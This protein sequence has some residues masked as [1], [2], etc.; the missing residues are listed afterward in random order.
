M[1][2]KEKILLCY[3]LGEDTTLYST[4][5]LLVQSN[6]K[7]IKENGGILR[8]CKRQYLRTSEYLPFEADVL[9]EKLYQNV[10]DSYPGY[11]PEIID[12]DKHSNELNT[13][14]YD[15]C[16]KNV[17][18]RI[19]EAGDLVGYI[20]LTSQDLEGWS[21]DWEFPSKSLDS[22]K[23]EIHKDYPTT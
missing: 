6:Y 16:T 2:N 23:L 3:A 1:C 14:V 13:L 20:K 4:I 12:E 9:L 11:P 18:I 10:S 15:W 21:D 7:V 5:D 19:F 8:V 17:H 22:E